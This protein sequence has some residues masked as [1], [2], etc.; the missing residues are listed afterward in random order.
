MSKSHSEV[1]GREKEQGPGVL[2]L[3]RWSVA[4]TRVLCIQSLL[5]NLKLKSRNGH[6]RR[7]H[8]HARAPLSRLPRTSSQ[9]SFMEGAA[10]FLI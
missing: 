6:G 10:L 5:E 1:T 4:G 7:K 8:V 2:S 9:G 3:L